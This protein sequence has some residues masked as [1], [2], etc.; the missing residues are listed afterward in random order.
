MRKFNRTVKIVRNA[1]SSL[2]SSGWIA[3]L[4]LVSLENRSRTYSMKLLLRGFVEG[5]ISGV[6]ILL[7]N[8]EKTGGSRSSCS[9]DRESRNPI[10]STHGR[11]RYIELFVSE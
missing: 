8:Q 7:F 5:D 10:F 9:V 3:L 1:S 2:I 6:S 4:D 11:M